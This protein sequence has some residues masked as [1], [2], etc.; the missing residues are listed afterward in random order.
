LPVYRPL[1]EINQ[2]MVNTTFLLHHPQSSRS[3]LSFQVHA[4][5]PG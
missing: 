3:S 4:N 5:R 1:S 2:E